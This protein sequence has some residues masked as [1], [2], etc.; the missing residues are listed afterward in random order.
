MTKLLRDNHQ[1]GSTNNGAS[2]DAVHILHPFVQFL[3]LC[4]CVHVCLCR[5]QSSDFSF[6]HVWLNAWGFYIKH[7]Y[8]CRQKASNTEHQAEQHITDKTEFAVGIFILLFPL[9]LYI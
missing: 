3:P 8:V 2:V 4:V 9:H 1:N 6:H 5:T 7:K